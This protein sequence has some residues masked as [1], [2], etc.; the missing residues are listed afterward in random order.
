MISVPF[1]GSKRFSY[2]AVRKIAEAGNYDAVYEPFGGSCVLSVDLFN[3]G[4]VKKAVT[5]DYDHFFTLYPEYLDLKDKVVDECYKRGLLRT[6]SNSKD[7]VIRFNPDG[8][9]EPVGRKTLSESD[10]AILRDV[11]SQYVPEK[12]WKYFVLGNNFTYSAASST[13]KTKLNDFCLF[14]AYLKTDRQRKYLEVLSQIQMEHLDWKDFIKKYESEIND[15]SLLILDPPYVGTNQDQYQGQFSV[16][17][18][19]LL[20]KTAASLGCD[21]IFFNHDM[22]QVEEWLDGLNYQIQ[23]TGNTSTTANRKR[24]DVMAYIVR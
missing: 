17:E 18:T 11:I 10:K 2:K 14:N 19:K 13:R 12:Y 8:T 22:D 3:D 9:K 24:K 1:S 7:G 16:E 21:F 4:L 23:L 15:K 6:T 20:I 5:N